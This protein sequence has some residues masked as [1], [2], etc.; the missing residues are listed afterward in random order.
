MNPLEFWQMVASGA[1]FVGAGAALAAL[2]A[3]FRLR[4]LSN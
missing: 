2:I 4:A 3:W 1:V